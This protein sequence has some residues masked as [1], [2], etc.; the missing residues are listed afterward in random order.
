MRKTVFVSTAFMLLSQCSA[1]E[2]DPPAASAPLALTAIEGQWD[3]VSFDGYR[4]ARLDSD[5]QRHAFVDIRGGNFSFA[6]ECNYSGMRGRVDGNRI[7]ATSNDNLQTEMG[8][9]RDR[10]ARD[11]TFF[12][13]LRGGPIVSRPSKDELVLERNGVRLE[14]QRPELRRR[15]LLPTNLDALEGEWIADILYHRSEPG[16]TDNLIAEL[17]GGTAR[18]SFAPG[19][20]TL[21]FDCET[22]ISEIIAARPGE[23]Q[24]HLVIRRQSGSC[25]LSAAD[26]DRAAS[27]VRGTITAENIPPD[28]LLLAAGDTYAVLRRE[29]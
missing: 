17:E 8:C 26:R 15:D 10:E 29:R 3:I 27:L 5:G 19:R 12:A 22:V 18:V 1:P 4:P 2:A 24:E 6:I 21:R 7:V 9:G 16:R 20:V 23:L 11:R 25:R 14:L 28:R 13:L